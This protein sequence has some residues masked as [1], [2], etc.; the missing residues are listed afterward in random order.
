MIYRN[1][2]L[3]VAHISFPRGNVPVRFESIQ[4]LVAV[5]VVGQLSRAL[6]LCFLFGD[7]CKNISVSIS[8]SESN[9][10]LISAPQGETVSA[11]LMYNR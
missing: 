7:R 8:V 9:S 10:I 4:E 11:S 1:K 3:T 2:L 5:P 6:V